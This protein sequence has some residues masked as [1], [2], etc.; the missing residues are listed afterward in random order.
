MHAH[1][2]LT[3]A[4]ATERRIV[5]SLLWA[6]PAAA[7]CSVLDYAVIQAPTDRWAVAVVSVGV[8]AMWAIIVS[9]ISDKA[10]VRRMIVEMEEY[11]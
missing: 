10:E 2:P 5:R 11:E 3:L 8:G 9:M 4:R 7:A 6:I 1:S